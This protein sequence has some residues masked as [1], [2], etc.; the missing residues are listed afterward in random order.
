MGNQQP[1]AASNKWSSGQQLQG[2]TEG[3]Q[4]RAGNINTTIEEQ[5]LDDSINFSRHEPGDSE[6]KVS[7]LKG[8]AANRAKTD[9]ETVSIA[10]LLGQIQKLEDSQRH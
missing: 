9:P 6:L 1:T 2:G 3:N 4:T 7:M 5:S 10:D 8:G